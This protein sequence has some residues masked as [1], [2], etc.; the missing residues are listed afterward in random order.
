MYKVGKLLPVVLVLSA[1]SSAQAA[2]K[3][4]EQQLA[5]QVKQALKTYEEAT[6]AL[7]HSK[8]PVVPHESHSA[9]PKHLVAG[10]TQEPKGVWQQ[11]KDALVT[12]NMKKSSV[13]S[14]SVQA[15]KLA[16][17][18]SAVYGSYKL[19]EY[20]YNKYYN[21]EEDVVVIINPYDELHS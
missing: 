14:L 12:D 1:Y 11:A 20:L 8:P 2:G 21:V 19:A 6:H 17:V 9:A 4:P 13:C 7:Q 18:L 16:A 10:A 5:D 15:L 3:A